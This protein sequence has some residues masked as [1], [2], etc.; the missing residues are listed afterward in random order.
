MEYSATRRK[1]RAVRAGSVVIG[2]G[3]PLSVQSMTN[4]DTHD[5]PATLRQVHA[6]EEAGADIVRLAVPDVEAA[7]T[8]TY[9]K[10]EGVR[11]PLVADIH[12]DYRIALAAVS[13]GA[14]K[15]RINPGNIGAR[16]KVKAVA[17]ACRAAGIPIR[18]GVN[19]GSLER[20][21]LEKYG[22]P[23][24][25]AL[26][27]SALRHVAILEALDFHDI[28]ISVKASGVPQMIA[29]NRLLAAQI[30]R[31]SCRERV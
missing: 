23:T 4:T 1:S 17:D 19:S 22:A 10:K 27:D 5:A 25:D 18:I 9:L 3:A 15:I 21:L 7:A 2:G 11:V 29:A 30:G 8:F 16:D 14:D 26:A 24:P 20:D 13:A 12:F 31:A 6:L 28:V